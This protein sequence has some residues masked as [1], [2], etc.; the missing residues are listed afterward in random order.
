MNRIKEL[1][2]HFFIPS[3]KNNLRAKALHH[4][5]LSFYLL[6]A[7]IMVFL[8]K[9]PFGQFKNV[10]GFATDISVPKLYEL[11]NQ[12]RQSNGLPQLTYNEAL[13]QAAAGKAQDMFAKNYWAHYAPDG[14]TPWNFILASGYQYE[15]AGE[16]LAKNFLFSQNVVD[17]WMASPTH[18][19]NIMRGDFSDVGFAVVNGVLNG[20]ETT[21]VVQ[22]FGKPIAAA[23]QAAVQAPSPPSETGVKETTTSAPIKT[24][25]IVLAQKQNSPKVNLFNI[26]F[27]TTFVFLSLLM[28]V[29]ATDFYFASKFHVIRFHSKN[30]AHF[31]FLFTIFLGLLLF[32]SK[33]VI[34]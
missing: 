16:N 19:E 30:V 1:I 34:L 33:G 14:A 10:L 26:S 21:L 20:E 27:D 25:G 22:L 23:P 28:I 8:V 7:L 24:A 15:Y 9:G 18:R 12:Q 13:A 6:I 2:S 3:E 17:A 32:L 31:L 29:L 4:D 5:F 11:I